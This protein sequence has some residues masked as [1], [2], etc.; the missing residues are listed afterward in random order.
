MQKGKQDISLSSPLGLSL[1]VPFF[2]AANVTSVLYTF[3]ETFCSY[4]SKC[5]FTYTSIQYVSMFIYEFSTP[6][7][8][9]YRILCIIL[10]SLNIA[11]RSFKISTWSAFTLFCTIVYIAP[12]CR[13]AIICLIRFLPG[14]FCYS[15]S[16]SVINSTALNH[17]IH[18][19]FVSLSVW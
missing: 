6:F 17:L 11:Y 13:C 2:M 5:I 12:G 3:L 10:F 16:F 8:T 1:P 4:A 18:V 15:Q 19:L 7:Y 14:H 9:N